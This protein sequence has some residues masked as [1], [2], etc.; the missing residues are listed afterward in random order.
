MRFADL[1]NLGEKVCRNFNKLVEPLQLKIAKLQ[2]RI[3]FSA[4]FTEQSMC[5]F[6]PPGCRPAV[7]NPC[8]FGK[9]AD[10]EC[11]HAETFRFG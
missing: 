7:L 2:D 4:I 9:L 1:E 6:T 3:D 11:L 5:F 10:V 8:R